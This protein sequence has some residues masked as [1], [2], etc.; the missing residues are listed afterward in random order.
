MT[1]HIINKKIEYFSKINIPDKLNYKLENKLIAINSFE[2][3][4]SF[5]QTIDKLSQP[6]TKLKYSNETKLPSFVKF[7]YSNLL[8]E[9]CIFTIDYNLSNT[10]IQDNIPIQIISI[11]KRNYT[12]AF[13][14]YIKKI[15]EKVIYCNIILIH[16]NITGAFENY[17]HSNVI[18]IFKNPDNSLYIGIYDPWGSKFEKKSHFSQMNLFLKT[19]S[20]CFL[21][22]GY[23]LQI[24]KRNETSKENGLQ[25]LGQDQIKVGYCFMFSLFWC[26]CLTN[27]LEIK[28]NL[29]NYN[30]YISSIE[31]EI[32]SN[33]YIENS[34]IQNEVNLN[35][36]KVILNFSIYFSQLYFQKLSLKNGKYF[37]K[38]MSDT[39]NNFIQK[40]FFNYEIIT[41]NLET[42]NFHKTPPYENEK[43]T[44][45]ND[46]EYCEN[47]ENC[48]SHICIDN[49]CVSREES[50]MDY[51]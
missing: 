25:I 26:Y 34:E 7:L 51:Y 14:E 19:I 40:D 28:N 41:E 38:V 5:F 37:Y 27:V 50:K 42:N 48:M 13:T 17:S 36:N 20:N 44:R 1:K 22:L 18:Y 35:L 47:D 16:V 32:L 30:N 2:Y 15:I 3:I 23:N 49:T 4:W 9:N 31:N 8:S 45:K 24:I 29:E 11:K 46:F 39:I 10:I 21:N 33:S 6:E 12:N 43:T